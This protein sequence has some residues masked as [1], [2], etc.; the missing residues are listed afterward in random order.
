MSMFSS[1]IFKFFF[2]QES[3]FDVTKKF[4]IF[5]DIIEI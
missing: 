2:W 3:E 1:Q 4:Q 5:K